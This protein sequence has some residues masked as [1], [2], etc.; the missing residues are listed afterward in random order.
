MARSAHAPAYDDDA[1]PMTVPVTRFPGMQW[2][3]DDEVV[4]VPVA[5]L[6]AARGKCSCQE[7]CEGFV[8]MLRRA[9]L[10]PV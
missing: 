4:Q 8:H 5:L 9:R 1:P 10:K 6:L 3:G 7:C 2:P